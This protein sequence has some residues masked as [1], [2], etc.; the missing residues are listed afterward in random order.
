ME[1]FSYSLTMNCTLVSL[2]KEQFLKKSESK[3]QCPKQSFCSD[4]STAAAVLR[5]NNMHGFR[6]LVFKL[7]E[8]Q[9]KINLMNNNT[10]SNSSMLPQAIGT[11]LVVSNFRFLW[12]ATLNWVKN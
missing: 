9:I 6:N 2:Q 8:E 10:L 1:V 4:K 7:Y 5:Y 3:K 12:L 11:L